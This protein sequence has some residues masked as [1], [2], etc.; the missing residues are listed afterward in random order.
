MRTP[1]TFATVQSA[2]ARRLPPDDRPRSGSISSRQAAAARLGAEL[3]HRRCGRM[4][5]EG[6]AR[7]SPRRARHVG[8][9][10]PNGSSS[11]RHTTWSPCNVD[12]TTQISWIPRVPRCTVLRRRPDDQPRTRAQDR[13]HRRRTSGPRPHHQR[14]QRRA[15]FALPRRALIVGPDLAPARRRQPRQQGRRP[16]PPRLRLD[17]QCAEGAHARARNLLASVERS[18]AWR[19]TPDDRLVLTLPLSTLTASV[20]LH[21]TL[22]CA[23]VSGAAP[24]L[25]S[26]SC[27]GTARD[28]RTL[29]FGVAHHV[30]QA[31]SVGPEPRTV[32]GSCACGGGPAADLHRARPR[33][34]GSVLE[35]V[36]S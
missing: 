15:R 21:G 35:Q 20:G 33:E 6:K 8:V 17:H 18:L 27:S 25:T 31:R 11:R 7:R 28:S 5:A 22:L 10:L 23:A 3:V 4:L 24:R 9:S 26:M 12:A 16:R 1:V 36:R 14:Q 19:S 2:W 30:S 34:V 32:P 29:F 13:W